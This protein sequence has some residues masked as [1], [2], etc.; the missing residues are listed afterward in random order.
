MTLDEVVDEVEVS[1]LRDR[2]VVI[3]VREFT[4][5]FYRHLRELVQFLHVRWSTDEL[6]L[7]ISQ[8][9]R[10][11]Y[12]TISSRRPLRKSIGIDLIVVIIVSLGQISWHRGARNLAGGIT[13]W[14]IRYDQFDTSDIR[15]LPGDHLL[16]A[17]ECILQH[18]SGDI[19]LILI[20]AHESYSNSTT[21][22]LTVDHDLG[23]FEIL[24]VANVVESSLRVDGDALLPGITCRQ[25]VASVFQHQNIAIQI[26]G[27]D[28]GNG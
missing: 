16:Y 14:S 8:Q 21:E 4:P 23:G 28:F 25:A 5:D 19:A 22:T 13:L 2:V 12:G 10:K 15:H 27:Q 11:T 26:V 9:G 24:A 1:S 17:E 3:A 20:P 7:D 6:S 18:Q